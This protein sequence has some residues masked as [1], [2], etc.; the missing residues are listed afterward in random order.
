MF[1][2]LHAAALGMPALNQGK[3]AA[4]PVN[5]AVATFAEQMNP[6]VTGQL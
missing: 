5:P 2:I 4:A 3:H 1:C 6:A